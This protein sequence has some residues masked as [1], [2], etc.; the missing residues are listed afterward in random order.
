MNKPSIHFINYIK[1]FA[2]L[3]VIFIH[4]RFNVQDKI[5]LE[6]FTPKVSFF[7]SVIYQLFVVCVPLFIIITGYF[8]TKKTYSK[9]LFKGLLKTVTLYFL[10]SLFVYFILHIFSNISLT[11]K[12]ILEKIMLYKLIGYSWYIEM[13]IGLILLSPIFNKIINHSTKKEMIQF[14]L[15]L[16]LT[17]NLPV[18]I[19]SLPQ[20]NHWIHL[21]SF[22]QRMYPI[23]YYFI[24]AYFKNYVDFTQ[25]TIKT[26]KII[27][28]SLV[29]ITSLGILFNYINA[30]PRTIGIEGGYPS[31]LIVLQ[32]VLTF[33][34]FAS[35]FTKENKLIR[36]V[37]KLTLP[38][39]LMS[40]SVDQ[41][42]YPYLLNHL[43]NPK[44]VILFF[45]VVPI[46][47]F[48]ISYILGSIVKKI[49]DSLWSL[50][51]KLFSL[52][53]NKKIQKD[54]ENC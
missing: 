23:T 48:C 30:N 35:I 27:F 31:L 53:L 38:I 43:D 26:K 34:F 37:A 13:Y 16:I 5:P 28:F 54:L 41:I 45:P 6:V 49:N 40:F 33:L 19:N 3:S 20:T 17:I 46:I 50:G 39:Y 18:L 44:Y 29:F 15:M 2:A 12:E 7:F 32:S 11:T 25:F 9:K 4:F 36:S 21:P 1:F 8:S 24:G 47:I 51:T 52:F 10:C 22:W 42:V 14:I